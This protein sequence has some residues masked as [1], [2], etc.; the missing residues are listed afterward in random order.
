MY[1]GMVTFG[2]A[3]AA[4]LKLALEWIERSLRLLSYKQRLLAF[5]KHAALLVDN[6]TFNIQYLDLAAE[7]GHGTTNSFSSCIHNSI[8]ELKV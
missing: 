5:Q 2:L 8:T 7:N 1:S 6:V 4:Q 3:H